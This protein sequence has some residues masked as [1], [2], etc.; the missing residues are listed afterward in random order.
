MT[1]QDEKAM[2]EKAWQEL[3]APANETITSR[4]YFEQG[5][6][7]AMACRVVLPSRETLLLAIGEFS[8]VCMKDNPKW[9]F[10]SEEAIRI[11]DKYTD[12]PPLREQV[13]LLPKERE[14]KAGAASLS[15]DV[16]LWNRFIKEIR[17]LNPSY[18][19]VCE[20]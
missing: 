18:K 20:K 13:I 4:W 7:A 9:V 3:K 8:A 14:I 5:F 12:I 6:K 10:P 19:C 2:R 15:S 1:P 16:A 11:V 17:A